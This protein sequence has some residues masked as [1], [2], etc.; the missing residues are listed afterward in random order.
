M[1]KTISEAHMEN[2]LNII[3][4]CFYRVHYRLHLFAKKAN[5]FNL[6]HKLPFQKRRYE[7]LG[8]DIHTEIDKA[9]SDK[10]IGLSVTVAGGFLWAGIAI[11]LF[12]V[13]LILNVHISMSYV[14]ICALTSGVISYVFVFRNEKYVEYFEIF[15]K[16]SKIE[17]RQYSWLTFG[18][19]LGVLGL[20]FLG[21]IT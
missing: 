17:K 18:S 2:Y 10:W 20:M 11:F 12:S 19:T 4:Y 16:W 9:F 6:I 14:V 13:L 1:N 15:E 7:Q 5:P 21:I 8:I 3:H